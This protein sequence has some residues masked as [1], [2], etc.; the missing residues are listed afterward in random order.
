MGSATH[1]RVILWK[2]R[3]FI[4]S[5]QGNVHRSRI[6]KSSPQLAADIRLGSEVKLLEQVRRYRDS[7]SCPSLLQCCAYIIVIIKT[8]LFDIGL[9]DLASR[10]DCGSERRDPISV[11]WA[12]TVRKYVHVGQSCYQEG[13]SSRARSSLY[14]KA[15]QLGIRKLPGLR[16]PP[17]L[18]S[19]TIGCHCTSQDPGLS[20]C[21]S[22]H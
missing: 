2:R 11:C 1:A 7:T 5:S 19:D 18:M 3:T 15:Q 8:R 6:A 21:S 14:E 17:Y 20:S 12:K 10:H 9:R 16:P 4:F 13:A 22:T